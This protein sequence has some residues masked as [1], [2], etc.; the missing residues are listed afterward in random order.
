[1]PGTTQ[2]P[3]KLLL[4]EDS[5]GDV[6]LTREALRD[7]RVPFELSV[8]DDGE[9]ALAYLFRTGAYSEAIRPDLVLLDINLPRKN[10]KQVLERLKADP[11]LR[12]IP[13]I[14]FST[15]DSTQEILTAYRLHANA[16][17]RKPVDLHH[18]LGVIRA[19]E[20]FWMTF[21]VFPVLTAEADAS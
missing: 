2:R 19:V 13:V 8:V 7:C 12:V 10:G 1:M 21:A 15:T 18:F 20:H 4:V 14:V 16:F 3:F 17:I 5:P 9:K 11:E 6:R